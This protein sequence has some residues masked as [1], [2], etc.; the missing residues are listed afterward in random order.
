MQSTAK[1]AALPA[2]T[3]AAL[4]VVF[5]DIGTSPLYALR[6]CFLTA[7]IAITEATVLGILS[8]I[9]WCMM[10]TISFKYVTI[11]MR[12]DNNG[13]GGIMSL[14][15]LNLRSNRIA[16]NRKIYLIALGFIGASLFFGDGIITPAI[17]VLSAIEGLSIAT[18]MFNKWLMPLAI[19]I[20]TAL[21][22]VQ[23]HGTGTM[24]KFFGPITLTW[25]ASI[26]LIGIHSISQTPYVLSMLSP[27]WALNFIF[28][29]PF[30]AFLTMGA[31]IL[32]V[33]GGEA[34]YAD[35][36]HFGRLP[37]RLGWFIIVLPCL[38]LNYAGQ[39]A[40]LLRNPSAIENPFYLLVPEW[41]LYPMIALATAAAVI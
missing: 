27:H 14:L 32:T 38:L 37:I 28:H 41:G 15:A 33:T 4:G 9:F 19:G 13:E 7:H 35:M 16:D 24:G 31:V 2:I 22:L 17:S 21:F 1:K 6:Q 10:L 29:Q 40:L 5:G 25:F 36:G 11:I 23:R 39:G 3:L 30:V 18:P 8:L 12:A 34:L 20:L 26:G